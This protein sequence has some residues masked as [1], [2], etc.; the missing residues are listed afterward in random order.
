MTESTLAF[1]VSIDEVGAAIGDQRG[2]ISLN[3]AIRSSGSCSHPIHLAQGDWDGEIPPWVPALAR[4]NY[5][6]LYSK[7]CGSRRAS[8]CSSCSLIYKGDA[9]ELVRCG[10]LGGKDQPE[11]LAEHAKIFATLTAPSFGLVHRIIMKNGKPERCHA[12]KTE[13]CRHGVK[14]NCYKRH[15]S[16]DEIVGAPLCC[17]CY[18]YK[19]CVIWNASVT[20]LWRRTTIYFNREVAK[21]LGMSRKEFS[22]KARIEYV[23]VVEFQARGAIHLHVVIR[24]DDAQ[25]KA[26]LPSATITPEILEVAFQT[27][28]RKVSIMKDFGGD[29]HRIVWGRQV[30][31]RTISDDKTRPVVNY[32]AK[33][34]T[35]SASE[36]AGF[37]RRF[38]SLADVERLESP[39][40]LKELAR[41]AF[42]LGIDG[43]YEKL[44]LTTWAHDLGYRGHFLTKSRRFSVT[45]ATLRS[46]RQLYRMD[47]A[48]ENGSADSTWQQT[49]T[50]VFVGQGW[51]TRA[52]AYWAWV[53]RENDLYER[54]QAWQEKMYQQNGWE[55][56]YG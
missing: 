50:M 5:E 49:G 2:W 25:V 53:Q 47:E 10:L 29:Q 37:D 23:K 22:A 21:S 54:E 8:R 34:S 38:K 43:P 14:L 36:S 45:F 44:N 24:V 1:G 30:D 55:N 20:D 18:D 52:H 41:T 39:K 15:S 4:T 7:A 13:Y 42:R 9:R 6:G 46:L 35:K 12:G 26:S 27:A 51:L 32:L 56:V 48:L 17:Q 40:H 33:Y 11:S 3:R 31:T 19:G 28:I 16:K